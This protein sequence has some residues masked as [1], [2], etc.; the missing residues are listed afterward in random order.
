MN[1]Y[2]F[3]IEYEDGYTESYRTCAVN[4][5]MAYEMLIEYLEDCGV[6][7][8]TVKAEVIAVHVFDE[9]EEA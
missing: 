4:K 6:D 1:E 7:P 2:E 9:E 3:D 8:A 5:L